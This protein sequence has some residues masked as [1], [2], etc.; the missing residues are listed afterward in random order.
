M[1]RN[2]KFSY[3]HVR[4]LRETQTTSLSDAAV[5]RLCLRVLARVVYIKCMRSIGMSLVCVGLNVL[6][7]THT[8]ARFNDDFVNVWTNIFT[9]FSCYS[10]RIQF[11]FESNSLTVVNKTLQCAFIIDW[12]CDLPS[13]SDICCLLNWVCDFFLIIDRNNHQ[14]YWYQTESFLASLGEVNF[15][16]IISIHT[17]KCSSYFA[18]CQTISSANF[19]YLYT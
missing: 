17:K 5:S 9:L 10:N 13:Y 8:L 2:K 7:Y 19:N 6:T 1:C 3:K 4:C 16:A 15:G 18:G 12:K 11:D 14:K